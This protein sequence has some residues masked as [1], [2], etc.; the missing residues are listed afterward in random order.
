MISFNGIEVEYPSVYQPDLQPVRGKHL[1][2]GGG[3]RRHSQNAKFVI[4]LGWDA[5]TKSQ[6]DVIIN[7]YMSQFETFN[8]LSFYFE[9]GWMDGD[10]G[11]IDVFMKIGDDEH[12]VNDRYK[13]SVV[14]YE[15]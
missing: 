11:P 4:K 5:L 14:L 9:G 2:L 8:P 1:I 13:L 10:L 12:L 3:Y 7:I 15:V 6:K